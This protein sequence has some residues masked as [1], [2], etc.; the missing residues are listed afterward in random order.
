MPFCDLFKYFNN[1]IKCEQVKQEITNFLSTYKI[2]FAFII[3]TLVM[4]L[5][6]VPS[7]TQFRVKVHKN[8]MH[9]KWLPIFSVISG[10]I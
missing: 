6:T 7:T 2:Q 4:V 8:S 3:D 10:D 9:R 1:L 5:K